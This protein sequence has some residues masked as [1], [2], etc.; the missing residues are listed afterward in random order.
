LMIIIPMVAIFFPMAAGLIQNKMPEY[1]VGMK[2]YYDK[3]IPRVQGE[4]ALFSAAG[5]LSKA[6][7]YSGVGAMIPQ[8]IPAWMSDYPAVLIGAMMLMMILP[9]LVGLHPVAIGTAL[10]TTIVP[11]S[12]GLKDMSFALTIITGWSFAILFSPFSAVSLIAGGLLNR[13]PWKISLGLSGKY[14]I[15]CLIIFSII[16]AY[17]NGLF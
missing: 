12:I 1:K 5:F 2:R 4:V 6:L 7:E 13:S 14:G 9:S 16:L 10:V 11:A 3:S 17:L 15:A 8:L